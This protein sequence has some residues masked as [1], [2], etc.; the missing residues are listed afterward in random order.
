MRPKNLLVTQILILSKYDYSSTSKC[1]LPGFFCPVALSLQH[2]LVTHNFV[3]MFFTQ[4][5]SLHF[6]YKEFSFRGM[7][8]SCVQ[9]VFNFSTKPNHG[10]APSWSTSSYGFLH[11]AKFRRFL[12]LGCANETQLAAFVVSS[13]KL[14]SILHTHSNTVCVYICI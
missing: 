1:L 11:F 13:G 5:I 7:R 9:L 2:W 6:F 8:R 3:N 14:F 12:F 10:V 4:L